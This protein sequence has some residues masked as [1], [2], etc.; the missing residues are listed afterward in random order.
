MHQVVRLGIIRY[1][2]GIYI[3]IC[4]K[5]LNPKPK[6]HGYLGPQVSGDVLGA[7]GFGG[8]ENL[9]ALV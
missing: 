4:P 8:S 9:T 7:L 6:V 2:G 5:I 3:Y 1:F